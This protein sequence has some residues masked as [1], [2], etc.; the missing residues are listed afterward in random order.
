MGGF[1]SGSVPRSG[2]LMTKDMLTLDIRGLTQLDLFPELDRPLYSVSV[3]IELEIVALEN[4]KYDARAWVGTATGY[5]LGVRPNEVARDHWLAD[6]S[7]FI[8]IT[9]T[10]PHLGGCRFWF[11]CPRSTCQRRCLVLYRED[12]TNARAFACRGCN[13]LAY[14]TQRMGTVGRLEARAEKE[15]RRI[16][17]TLD[18][19]LLRPK[20]MRR[21]TFERIARKVNALDRAADSASEHTNAS[22]ARM[23]ETLYRTAERSRGVVAT[24]PGADRRK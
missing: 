8:Q 9:E 23:A 11:R 1:G 12:H 19:E 5:G 6:T 17:Q 13:R 4:G 3:P 7:M 14:P 24:M 21:R 18:G 10:R 20:W 22:L 2:R 16:I 15:V